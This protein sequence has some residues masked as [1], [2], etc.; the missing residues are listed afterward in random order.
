LPATPV[1]TAPSTAG[2]GSPNRTASVALHAGSTYDWS[3]VNGTITAGQGTSSIT[4]TTGSEGTLTLYVS[5]TNGSACPS[6]LASASVTVAPPGSA[7]Q[8]YTVPPCRVVDTR[9]TSGFPAGYGP[10]SMAGAQTRRDFVLAGPCG[11]PSG[12]QAVSVNATVW[13]PVTRGDMR[14]FPAGGAMPTVSM[15][16]WEANILALANAAILQL[17]TGGAITVQIDGP[18]TVDLILDVNGYFQ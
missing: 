3:I 2:A 1:I 9:A 7:L 10:P 14:V 13:A 11:I 4:F 5:E 16:N 17:G 15:L 8:F 12:A 18:G 6:D